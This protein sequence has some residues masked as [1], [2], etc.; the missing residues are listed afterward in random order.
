MLTIEVPPPPKKKKGVDKVT[1]SSD[2]LFFT[3]A[4]RGSN[5]ASRY[6]AMLDSRTQKKKKKKARSRA[7]GRDG[8]PLV[9]SRLKS[10]EIPAR[11]AGGNATERITFVAGESSFPKR[12]AERTCSDRATVFSASTFF[13]GDC[14][15]RRDAGNVGGES[16]VCDRE[17]P[18]E[19]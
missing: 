15:S 11:R 14:G 6:T 13:A 2:G 8:S 7:R 4:R 19:H 3:Y 1:G 12:R 9:G 16:S 17:R 10:P 18:R 5:D